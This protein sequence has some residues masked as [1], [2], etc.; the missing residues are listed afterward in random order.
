MTQAMRGL[1]KLCSEQQSTIEQLSRQS[2]TVDSSRYTANTED[3]AG[4]RTTP[5]DSTQNVGRASG[6]RTGTL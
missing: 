2:L 1:Q 4:G 3:W 5:T 6:K